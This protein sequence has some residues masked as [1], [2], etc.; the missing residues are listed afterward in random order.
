MWKKKKQISDSRESEIRKRKM[1]NRKTAE[2]KANWKI[3]GALAALLAAVAAFTVMLQMEKKVLTQYERGSVL[4]AIQEV[5][6]GILLT[7]ENWQQYF[8]EKQIDKSVLPEKAVTA[9]V[10]IIGYRPVYD[11]ASGTLLTENMFENFN[12]R[13][14]QFKEPVIAGVKADDIYQVNPESRGLIDYLDQFLGKYTPDV[15]LTQV[16]TND[17]A[18]AAGPSMY[19]E[20]PYTDESMAALKA[21]WNGYMDKLWTLLPADGAIIVATVPPTTRTQCFDDWI[22]EFNK[23]IPAAVARYQAA[24]RKSELAPTNRMISDSTPERGLCSD[25]VH[26]SAKGYTAMAT[27]Y[28]QAFQKLYPNTIGR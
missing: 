15:V 18:F 19:E 2:K 11:I 1:E 6:R 25:Q 21:R 23:E 13:L 26:L 10:Q 4:T 14:E 28:Y 20:V 12:I 5:P 17:C 9:S 16:G 27:A 22:N 3:S 24:G 8:A 7:E